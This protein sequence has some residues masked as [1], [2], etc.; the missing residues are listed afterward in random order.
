MHDTNNAESVAK[1]FDLT[2]IMLAGNTTPVPALS[3]PLAPESGF[4]IPAQQDE[5]EFSAAA[6]NS[7][8][9]P[10]DSSLSSAI[11]QPRTG[12]RGAP[13][14]VSGVLLSVS[15][16]LT[17]PQGLAIL[18]A[19]LMGALATFL[20]EHLVPGRQK[21]GPSQTRGIRPTVELS[22][23]CNNRI[24]GTA[25]AMPFPNLALH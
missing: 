7:F 23:P 24:S 4:V 9:V 21:F 1:K 12:G 14:P 16:E 22:R 3:A 6:S 10:V 18:E 20:Q 25:V 13:E 8:R 2:F 15:I 5:S 11:K 19:V 17:S